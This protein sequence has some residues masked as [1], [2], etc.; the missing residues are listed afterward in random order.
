LN[1]YSQVRDVFSKTQS[2]AETVGFELLGPDLGKDLEFRLKTALEK[3]TI[4]QGGGNPLS[5]F[6]SALQASI[7]EIETDERGRLFQRFLRFG[8]YEGEGDIPLELSDQRLRDVDTAKCITFIYSFMVNSFK[9]A[10]T[11]L[12]AS[13]A[14]EQVVE[15]ICLSGTLPKSS[16]LYVGDSVMIPREHGRG[17][18]KGADM[19]VLVAGQQKSGS[20]N[21]TLAGVVEVKSGPR[22]PDEVSRQLERHILRAGHGLRV[23]GL[24]YRAENVLLGWGPEKRIFRIMVQPSDWKLPRTFWFENTERGRTLHV[25][26]ATPS[27]EDSLPSDLNHSPLG[28]KLKWSKEAIAQAAYE[29]TFWYMEEVGKIIYSDKNEMPKDWRHMTPAEAGRNAVKMMLYYAIPRCRTTRDSQRAIALYNT[30]GF[31]YALG[32][33][34]KNA[35]GRREMLWP[36]DLDE[37]LTTG[38]TKYGCRI[39]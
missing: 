17:V 7:R 13:I 10:L 14:C 34:F 22:S 1:R 2:L 28:I 19:N 27:N 37:I 26:K 18:L 39:T 3:G 30:Y 33:N 16:R 29:M 38:K 23:V 5:I 21:I 32:M 12:L 20:P 6:K 15:R 9:G 11:E 4:F 25:E 36:E 8:P 24:D 31:G 35:E